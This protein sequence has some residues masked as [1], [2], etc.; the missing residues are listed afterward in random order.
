MRIR[1][2]I[3]GTGKRSVRKCYPFLPLLS[4]TLFALKVVLGR[5][6]KGTNLISGVILYSVL[7]SASILEV[8]FEVSPFFKHSTIIVQTSAPDFG[9]VESS[10]QNSSDSSGMLLTT[11]STWEGKTLIPPQAIL[12]SAL[13]RI[14]PG[15]RAWVR[16]HLHFLLSNLAISLVQ[17]RIMGVASFVRWVSTRTPSSP[18]LQGF[19][20]FGLMT[21][22]RRWSST[23]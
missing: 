4:T 13:P 3:T 6:P 9:S 5:V 18:C 10:M 14:P 16:P 22:I 19:F 8:T 7:S 12:S 21:S 23:Q 20:V 11:F 15:E 17:N 1:P 2:Q